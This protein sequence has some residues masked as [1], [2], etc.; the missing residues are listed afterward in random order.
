[1]RS[2]TTY[3]Q[4]GQGDYP[5]DLFGQLKL[6]IRGAQVAPEPDQVF[7]EC[8]TNQGRSYPTPRETIESTA[9][10]WFVG[11]GLQL[12]L[13]AGLLWWG[14]ARTRTPARRSATRHPHRLAIG[15]CLERGLGVTRL[16]RETNTSPRVRGGL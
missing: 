15:R 7:D 8:A 6:T 5:R 3:D 4:G 11:L 2:P 10:S 12:V 13:A 14:W 9:P 1:M 16:D